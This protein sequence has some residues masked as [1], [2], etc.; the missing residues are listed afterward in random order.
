MEASEI[1][2]RKMKIHIKSMVE[3]AAIEKVRMLKSNISVMGG[4]DSWSDNLSFD[5]IKVIL[6]NVTF[7]NE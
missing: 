5:C 7:S 2:Y 1:G 6:S 3:K 4:R